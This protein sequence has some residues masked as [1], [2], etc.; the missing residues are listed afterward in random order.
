MC[1]NVRFWRP[2]MWLT[3]RKCWSS[4]CWFC[5]TS[6]Q[7]TAKSSQSKK[8][9]LW[10]RV[11]GMRT[12]RFWGFF[13]RHLDLKHVLFFYWPT[14]VGQD[15]T[16]VEGEEQSRGGGLRTQQCPE[17]SWRGAGPG[18]HNRHMPST[19]LTVQTKKTVVT[20]VPENRKSHLSQTHSCV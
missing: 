14:A 2:V 20:L 11:S 18:E 8:E 16:V 19:Y 3:A 9:T 1:Q 5:M 4:R 7:E 17:T 12:A 10:R 15:Q 13:S 6:S